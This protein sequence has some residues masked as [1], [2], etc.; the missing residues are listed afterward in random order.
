MA[1]NLNY[2][3]QGSRCYNDDNTYCDAYGRLYDWATAMNIDAIYNTTIWNGSVANHRGVCP[4]GWHVPNYAEW[5][6]LT[7][8]AGGTNA[9]GTKLKATSGWNAHE[10]YGNGTDDYGFAAL[11]AGV[12]DE[13]SGM[14][15]ID[16]GNYG[17][18]WST[19]R[20]YNGEHAT[21]AYRKYAKYD[22][23]A[24][25]WGDGSKRSMY[26]LR[27]VRDS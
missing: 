21:R 19:D 11:P 6:T 22:N 9:A 14:V 10:T 23:S 18:W 3:A 7:N 2:A 25:H 16:F 12:L 8:Y 24:F 13:W 15:F 27:C 4:Q 26:N 5:V 20:G 1:E 17:E